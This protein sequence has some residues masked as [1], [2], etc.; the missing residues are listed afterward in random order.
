MKN[1]NYGDFSELMKDAEKN[2]NENRPK[3]KPLELDP[4]EAH[5]IAKHLAIQHALKVLGY[6]PEGSAEADK[7]VARFDEEYG[8]QAQ[9]WGF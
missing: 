3:R 2:P 1:Y 7:A 9:Y 5:R 8:K 6:D 4:A